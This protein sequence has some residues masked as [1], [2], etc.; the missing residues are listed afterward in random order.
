MVWARASSHFVILEDSENGEVQKIR[1]KCIYKRGAAWDTELLCF[2]I[3]T[4]DRIVLAILR[5]YIPSFGSWAGKDFLQRPSLRPRDAQ[6]SPRA[7]G[8]APPPSL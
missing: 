1:P 4:D 6:R 7:A 8:G 3:I 2:I 5:V